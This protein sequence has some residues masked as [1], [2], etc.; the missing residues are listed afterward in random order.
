VF[1]G[2]NKNGY[3]TLE[4]VDPKSRETQRLIMNSAGEG[5][6]FIYRY[7]HRPAERTLFTKDYQVACTKEGESLAAGEKKVEC[8]VSGGPGK[9]PVSYNGMTYDVCCSGCRDAFNENPEKYIKRIRSPEKEALAAEKHQVLASRAKTGASSGH[10]LNIFVPPQIGQDHTLDLG[11]RR[12]R[13]GSRFAPQRLA[14]L[15]EKL[16]GP[17][18]S[19]EITTPSKRCVVA[20]RWNVPKTRHVGTCRRRGTL[21]SAATDQPGCIMSCVREPNA[22]PIAGYRLIEPLGSGGFGEVWKCEAPGGLFK[23]IKFVYGN[24]NS[25]DVDGA[26]AEQELKALQRIKEVRHPFV[27]SLDRI[28]IVE[29]ELVIVMELADKNLHDAFVECQSA[30]LVGIPR[31]ALLRYVRDAAEALDHMHEKHSLQHLDVKPRNLFLICDRVKVA[32][33]G[34]VNHLGRASDGSGLL[35]GVTPLYAPPET[36][37]GKITDRSDQYSLAIVYQELVTGQRPFDGKNARQ[38]AQ[39]HMQSEPELRSLPEPERPV[40]A[41]A[42]SKDPAKRFPNCL[43]F[44]RSL[45]AAQGHVRLGQPDS[46]AGAGRKFKSLSET[47]EDIHLEMGSEREAESS[48]APAEQQEEVSRLGIT[49]AQP[50]SG[51]LRPTIIIAAGGFGRRALRELRCRFLDRLGDLGKIPILRFLYVD[52]D[53]QAAENALRGTP[54]IALSSNE[55]YPLPLQNAGQYRR[56]MLDYLSEWLPREK[57]YAIP[58]S[59]QTQGSRALGRLAFVDNHLRLLARLRREIQEACHPDSIY[60]AVSQTGLALR[61]SVPRVYVLAAAGGGSSGY[62]VDLGYG[63]RRL[64]QQLR[65]PEAELG[66]FLFC[67]A[68]DDPATPPAEQANVYATLTELNHFADPAIP[69]AAQYGADGPRIVDQ[70]DAFPFTYLL[71]VGHRSPESLRDAVAHLGSYLFHELTTPLGLRLARQRHGTPP[72]GATTFRSFGTY[73]VWFPRGLLLRL[74][75][76]QVCQCLLEEWQAAGDPTAPADVEAACGRVSADPELRPEALALQIEEATRPALNASPAEA[77]TALL[78]KL[79]EQSQQSIAEDDPGSWAR[80]ALTRVLEWVGSQPGQRLQTGTSVGSGEWLQSKLSRALKTAVEQL[81]QAWDNRLAEVAYGLMQHPGHR[82]AN[83]E[84]ALAELVAF[85]GVQA[86]DLQARSQ[87]QGPRTQHAWD[88]LESGLAG[89]M[90]EAGNGGWGLPSLFGNR[91]RRSLRVFMDYL[92]AFARQ[93]QAEELTKAVQLFF[94]MLGG[95]LEERLRQLTFCRQRLRHLAE[96][97][98]SPLDEVLEQEG[99]HY[100]SGL[101]PSHSPL[102]SPESFWESIRQS[103]TVRVVL[104]QTEMDLEQAAAWAANSLKPHQQGELDQS[105]H[106]RVLAP[107]GGLHAICDG[108]GDL[109]RVLAMPLL[110]QAAQYIDNQLPVTDV[111]QVE[112]ETTAGQ[113]LSQQFHDYLARAVPLV[114]GSDPAQQNQ[115]L[116]VP[117][118]EA[119][120]IYG[121]K[122]RAAA[123]ELQLVR[124][125][126]QAHLMF[127]KEQGYLQTADLQRV[128]QPCRT[129][130]EQAA[131][132]P[133][134][135]PHSRFDIVD[136]V[137]IDP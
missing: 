64:L 58:R 76:R 105:L 117:A 43:A 47:L 87:N 49:I 77:V 93:C 29:G 33:F 78:S 40:V 69:F 96:N 114:A 45:Y 118:S 134:S 92:A 4:R 50:E 80:Q 115:F 107:L 37:N 97:L 111:A 125:P 16:P 112:L 136:W 81:A 39:Q 7:A 137:P 10:L 132:T 19:F 59:L 124:V 57:L 9:V 27:L 36:F 26:R 17:A 99:S 101:T 82:V 98:A 83:A 130:Y 22:E 3:L 71:Q 75:A 54:E 123:P 28:E 79:D 53:P 94:S 20:A 63:L 103:A 128:L 73:A 14:G 68:P 122:A 48:P 56:R 70:G 116:L 60:Q 65:A 30:G 18:D 109:M 8:P 51:V 74:A 24:L 13:S 35:G 67:G 86:A 88:L 90:G 52:T 133:V 41:R 6:R 129:A 85:C 120:K 61:D 126:G 121:E 25:L 108:S 15:E 1:T 110:A 62:V 100:S 34:L 95:K 42:L 66:L 32:D 38:L 135:S 2:E 102:P 31:E 11:L 127:C 104:P 44:V 21:E 91:A 119:G 55:V 106:D 5:V 89:C 46:A 84:A 72:A 131:V 113:D 23:A 12:Y